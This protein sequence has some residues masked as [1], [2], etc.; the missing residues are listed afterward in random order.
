MAKC[1]KS[2]LLTMEDKERNGAKEHLLGQEGICSLPT[3]S[4]EGWH[5]DTDK[6][7]CAQGLAIPL[8]GVQFSVSKEWEGGPRRRQG[9]RE[10]HTV[11]CACKGGPGRNSKTRLTEG[12]MGTK[13]RL[14]VR[15]R[16]P[17]TDRLS[18]QQ[19]QVCSL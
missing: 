10:T 17:E 19:P 9:H 4:P 2:P 16:R 11:I 15:A 12:K 3:A 14:W 1:T 6:A 8:T 7:Q 13:G 18:A 5:R